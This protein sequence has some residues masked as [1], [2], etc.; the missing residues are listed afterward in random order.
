MGN[1]LYIKLEPP[2]ERF[3][4]NAR[5]R[6][7]VARLIGNDTLDALS[8]QLGVP[9]LNAFQSYGP[10]AVLEFLSDP[11]EIAAAQAK[12]PPVEWFEPAA[13]LGALHEHYSEAHFIVQRGRKSPPEDRTDDLLED[14]LDCEEILER[15]AAAGSRFRF[16]LVT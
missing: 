1:T 11:A 16:Y 7:F 2:L 8:E 10:E 14:L 13:A 5:D 15:A 4:P 9:S 6:V 12:M 3:D